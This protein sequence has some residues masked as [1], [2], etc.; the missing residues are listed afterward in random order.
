M[1]KITTGNTTMMNNAR[2]ARRKMRR[3]AQMVRYKLTSLNDVPIFFA[4][5]FPKSGT[6]LLTQVVSGFTK[7]GPAVNSGLSAIVTYEGVTGRKRTEAEIL[8]DLRQLLPADIAYG[9]LHALPKVTQYLCRNGFIPYFIL[10]DPRDVAVS[11]V[12][13]ITDMAPNHI[14]HTYYTQE[15]GSFNERLSASITGFTYENDNSHVITMPNILERFQPYMGW[16]DHTEVLWL[17]FED[18]ITDPKSTIRLIL[19][20]ATLRG[21]NITPSRDEAVQTLLNCIQPE[22][23]PTFRKG[24]I[25]GWKNAFTAEHKKQFK[26]VTGDLLLQLGYEKDNNW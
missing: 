1:K 4:N 21:F 3:V 10:R 16:L 26:D 11:H 19:E 25:G 5:S 24:T 12:H 22:Q 7:I 14:H 9:H 8:D 6:H 20:H 17:R 18:F 23:S 2:I 15:L 13:Y